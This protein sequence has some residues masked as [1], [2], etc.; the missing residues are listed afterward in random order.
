[1]HAIAEARQRLEHCPE[2]R[3]HRPRCCPCALLALAGTLKGHDAENHNASAAEGPD[4]RAREQV[5]YL[6][7][8]TAT[9]RSQLAEQ[10]RQTD[11]DLRAAAEKHRSDLTNT[12]SEL[13]A[14]HTHIKATLRH[15]REREV[16]HVQQ[17]TAAMLRQY[18]EEIKKLQRKLEMEVRLTNPNPNP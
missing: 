16:A 11:I 2:I 7:A 4:P 13:E 10:R 8:E 6:T 18:A 1:M 17:E 3:V 9:L 12:C 15:E 5:R 14:Q